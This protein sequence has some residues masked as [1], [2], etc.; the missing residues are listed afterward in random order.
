M[1]KYQRGWSA[2]QIVCGLAPAGDGQIRNSVYFFPS[3]ERYITTDAL[4][5]FAGEAYLQGS[6]RSENADFLTS[7]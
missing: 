3:H 4:P 5:R 1:N 7:A 6:L 2:D